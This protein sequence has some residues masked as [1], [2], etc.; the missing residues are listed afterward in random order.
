MSSVSGQTGGNMV[1][2]TYDAYGNTTVNSGSPL[3]NPYQYNAEYTDS[4]TGNQYLR[5]RYYDPASGRFLTKD[6]YLGE[7]ND[8]L[9]RNLYAYTRNNPVNLVDPSGHLF[10]TIMA[11]IAVTAAVVGTYKAVKS[12]N[13]QSKQIRN[14]QASYERNAS[15]VQ[16][17]VTTKPSNLKAPTSPNQKGTFSYYNERDKKVVT[18]TNAAAYFEYKKLCD[19]LDKLDK[20]LALSIVHNTLDAAGVIPG[21]G[22]V[23]DAA[24]GFIYLAE[25]D[26]VNAGLSFLSCIPVA[27][28]A[29]G[30]GGKA[31]N[32]ALDYSDDA[33]DLVSGVTKY[34]DDVADFAGDV[35]K[36]I[37]PPKVKPDYDNILQDFADKAD[38]IIN[39]DPVKGNRSQTVKGT[40]SS[41]YALTE[42]L[43]CGECR[44]P[45]RRCTWTAKGQKK[46]VWRCINRLDYGK[47]Y[48]HHS[49]TIEESVLQ[50]AIMNA[51]MVTAKQN[52]EVLKTLKLHIGMGLD[53]EETE[54]KC[55]DI[56][57][58]IAEI[59][60]EFKAMVQAISAQT[61]DTF[62]DSRATALMNEKNKLL[63]QL[64]QIGVS[65]QK[66]ENAKS[67]LT[68]I[69]TILDGLKNHPMTYDD[70]LIRQ[71]LE[72]VI[73]ESKEQIKV[74]FIGG[75]EVIQPLD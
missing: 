28:D 34:G 38:D 7:T 21:F 22:E 16:E 71:I 61:A 67:R 11:I 72:C 57:I 75:T 49:P 25:G 36:H 40:Y 45:Y 20:N 43:I 23:A 53:I 56:Q 31:L 17:N 2:Y 63:G 74:V 39:N 24:N 62:D 3:N 54:D 9:S 1:S 35:A 15:S 68:E 19:E 60:A 59:D 69:Y 30:K 29:A 8:P 18:F 32:T 51:V 13:E 42:L 66:R 52:I 46:I 44:T 41:K 55:L 70:Q 26:V 37:D 58:R 14:Q 47:K 27:G 4:S 48:C 65:K 50:Q 33:L 12:H 5:A 10:G 73:V 64:E 6:T